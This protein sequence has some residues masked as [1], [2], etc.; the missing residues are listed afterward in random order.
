MLAVLAHGD[1]E[2]QRELAANLLLKD[3]KPEELLSVVQ[4]ALDASDDTVQFLTLQALSRRGREVTADVVSD[5]EQG[6]QRD[7]R[8]VALRLLL[9]HYYWRTPAGLVGRERYQQHV[10]WVVENRPDLAVVMGPEIDLDPEQDGSLYVQVRQVWLRHI[11]GR[12]T[13]A[14]FIGQAARHFRFH[15]PELAETLLTKAQALE[16]ENPRWREERAHLLSLHQRNAEKLK[17][18][19]SELRELEGALRLTTKGHERIPLLA[20]LARAAIEEGDLNKAQA[21]AVESLEQSTKL[22][23]F[24][25][26]ATHYGNLVLGRL[27]LKAGHV[28][29]AKRHLLESARTSGSPVQRSFGPNMMLAKELLDIGERRIVIEY[30]KLCTRFWQTADHQAEQWIDAIERGLTPDFGANLHY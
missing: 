13:N 19:T 15:E 12:R 8:N 23:A 1:A 18:K 5:L 25:E 14:A 26:E 4:T 9:L 11:E 27:A 24:E 7:P 10:R 6:V 16:P 21:Y 17:T 22:N 3:S 2:A 28:D 20:D 29:T 30:L